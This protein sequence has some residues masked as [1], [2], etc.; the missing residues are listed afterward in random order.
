M[1]KVFGV[2]EAEAA[3]E[4][5][6]TKDQKKTVLAVVKMLGL[7]IKL[8]AQAT[9]QTHK[10]SKLITKKRTKITNAVCKVVDLEKKIDRLEDTV[11]TTEDKIEA[12][13]KTVADWTL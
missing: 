13:H 9:N 2:K 3:G 12:V 6:E 8:V 7:P 10:L 4:F 11:D 5:A 1:I